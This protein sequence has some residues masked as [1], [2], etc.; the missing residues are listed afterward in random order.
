MPQPWPAAGGEEWLDPP[1]TAGADSFLVTA[2]EPQCGQAGGGS[3]IFC[4]T[5]KSRLQDW[6][7]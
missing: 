5:V 4:I 1:C 7:A 3:L 2:S 6:Q